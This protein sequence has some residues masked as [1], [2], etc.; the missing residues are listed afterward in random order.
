MTDSV[1][2][3]LR[4]KREERHLSLEQVSETTR[5]RAHYLKALESD[6]L[7]SIPSAAQARGFLRNYAEFLGLSVDDLVPPPSEGEPEPTAVAE[8]PGVESGTDARE[9]ISVGAL[10]ANLR[11]RFGRGSREVPRA[12]GG[13]AAEALTDSASGKPPQAGASAS[14][15]SAPE[16]DTKRS[17][18]K[19]KA[20]K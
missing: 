9:G 1:G 14:S 2:A 17:K 5:I 20:R 12:E 18:R 19:K 13:S 7:S 11:S 8:S 4:Q 15:I 10:L 3:R 6:D 16:P